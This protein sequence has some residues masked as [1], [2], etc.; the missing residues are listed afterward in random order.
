MKYIKILIFLVFVGF[1]LFVIYQHFHNNIIK[2]I[3]LDFI[4][5]DYNVV[6]SANILS[7]RDR[8]AVKDILDTVWKTTGVKVLFVTLNNS[9]EIGNK[10]HSEFMLKKWSRVNELD[11]RNSL[12]ISIYKKNPEIYFLFTEDLDFVMTMDIIE[13]AMTF[14]ES[15]ISKADDFMKLS[16]KEGNT[17]NDR[18]KDFIGE[19]LLKAVI[20][21]KDELE[22]AILT[23]SK[24][25]FEIR[26]TGSESKDTRIEKIILDNTLYLTLIFSF[27]FLMIGFL[28]YYTLRNRCPQCGNR[29][30]KQK[31]IISYPKDDIPGI[32]EMNFSCT[33]CG[34][35]HKERTVFF[36][37][38]FFK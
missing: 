30:T 10:R 29:M 23:L 36:E 8:V 38:R 35:T 18:Y 24:A 32:R 27:I 5:R 17:S 25:E 14:I 12:L 3:N 1:S 37:K 6:D 4:S 33:V 2:E 22:S 13:K 7:I 15:G 9:G 28:I 26:N 11:N 16:I 31:N 19:G 20:L 34:F 21:I